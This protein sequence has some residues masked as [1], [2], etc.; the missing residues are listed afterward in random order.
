MAC[1]RFSNA[2]SALHIRH[3]R[4]QLVA[5]RICYRSTPC[6]RSPRRSTRDSSVGRWR[7]RAS[8]TSP[9]GPARWRHLVSQ[10]EGERKS[11]QVEAHQEQERNL[12]GVVR[13]QVDRNARVDYEAFRESVQQENVWL[14]RW[15]QVSQ[16]QAINAS[17]TKTERERESQYRFQRRQLVQNPRD[18][19]PR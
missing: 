7:S 2:T 9:I 19:M 10:R 6:C 4:L 17:H 14:Y 1:R 11:K 3:R 16:L 12:V 8:G 15:S 18:R 13:M 5:Q